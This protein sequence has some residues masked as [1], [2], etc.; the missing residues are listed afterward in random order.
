LVA[1]LTP[2]ESQIVECFKGGSILGTDEIAALT[3][4]PVSSLASNLTSLE[5]KKIIIR[6]ADG[7][8]EAI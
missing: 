1:E 8:F 3:N 6:R 7:G 4:L 5:L 2:V